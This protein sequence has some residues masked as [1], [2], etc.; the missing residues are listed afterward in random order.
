MARGQ[1]FIE[2]LPI[3]VSYYRKLSSGQNRS[4]KIGGTTLNWMEEPCYADGHLRW[5]SQISP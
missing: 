1:S 4:Y 3:G 5:V 2:F